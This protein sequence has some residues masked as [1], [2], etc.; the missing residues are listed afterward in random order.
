[1]IS[2]DRSLLSGKR[3]AFWYTLEIFSKQFDRIDII[4]PRS[5]DAKVDANNPDALTFFGNTH[6]HPSPKGLLHQASWIAS[7][8]AQLI[9]LFHHSVMTV[10]DYPPFYNSIGAR[11]LLKKFPIGSVLEIHHLVGYPKAASRT[12]RI[13][14]ILSRVYL[15]S[16]IRHFT[17]TRVVNKTTAETLTQWGADKS[18]IFVV[19]SVYL[20]LPLFSS[21]HAL[22]VPKQYDVAFCGRLVPNKGLLPLLRAIAKIPGVSLLVIGDGP[23]R[24][25]AESYARQL[26][27]A[28]RVE[29]RGWLPTQ[30]DVLRAMMS[31]KCFVMNSLSEGNPRVAIE[32]MA[33]GL[34]VI[35]TKVGIM[36]DVLIEGR[37]GYFTT[38]EPV[39]LADV[40]RKMLAD[41][42]R[43]EQMGMEARAVLDRFEREK[44]IHQYAQFVRSAAS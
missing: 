23:E 24:K 34:P 16:A 40:I 21:L 10:H 31:A 43:R 7:R 14:R 28:E 9:S 1:M 42:G 12:E 44:Q 4:T 27:I 30:E 39:D 18:K 5:A 35:A 8:G 33:V 6:L 3:G 19:P 25:A 13:G 29:F 41:D 20:D 37:N 38:G 2:G 11:R 26:D 32:A 22:S 36:P 17:A 15:P